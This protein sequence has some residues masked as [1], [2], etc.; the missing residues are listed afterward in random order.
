MLDSLLALYQD[1]GYWLVT[2]QR[3]EGGGLH[4]RHQD[5]KLNSVLFMTFMNVTMIKFREITKLD[6]HS[7][8]LGPETL[9]SPQSVNGVYERLNPNT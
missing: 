8:A 3:L 5:S 6:G 1:S 7:L 4:F 9:G 2:W